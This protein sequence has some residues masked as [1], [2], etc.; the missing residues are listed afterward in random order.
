MIDSE[1]KGGRSVLQTN[2]ATHRQ[3]WLTT[4]KRFLNHAEVFCNLVD[5]EWII[6][7]T[8]RRFYTEFAFNFKTRRGNFPKYF[9]F[10]RFFNDWL[11]K[12]LLDGIGNSM[13]FRWKF[14]QLVK[15]LKMYNKTETWKLMSCHKKKKRRK[16]EKIKTL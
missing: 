5:Y 2:A 11:I 6:C 16:E 9:Y 7:Y 1:P 3:L 13:K 15:S 12:D 8:N 4:S 10:I 14:N